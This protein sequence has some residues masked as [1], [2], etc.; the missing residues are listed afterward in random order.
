MMSENTRVEGG[1]GTDVLLCC[2]AIRCVAL[3]GSVAGKSVLQ[4]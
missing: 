4:S 2:L 3:G 1:G